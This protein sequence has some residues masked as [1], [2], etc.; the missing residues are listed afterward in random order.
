VDICQYVYV[1]FVLP[2]YCSHVIPGPY[3]NV[4][5]FGFIFLGLGPLACPSCWVK[6]F[7]NGQTAQQTHFLPDHVRKTDNI[8]G[9]TYRHSFLD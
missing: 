4:A 8:I 5:P 6:Q 7:H 2:Q 1:T 9:T 3:M